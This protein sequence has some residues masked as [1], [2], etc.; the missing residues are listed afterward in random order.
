MLCDDGGELEG[1]AQRGVTARRE[2]TTGLVVDDLWVCV[3]V[4]VCVCV[5]FLK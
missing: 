2:S 1:D 4:C 3:C 5:A